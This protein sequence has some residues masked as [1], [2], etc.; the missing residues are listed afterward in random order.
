MRAGR[1][2]VILFAAGIVLLV[3]VPA[4]REAVVECRWIARNRPFGMV[5]P[6]IWLTKAEVTTVAYQDPHDAQIWLGY[7]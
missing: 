4:L 1:L 7:A 2:T 3:A 5:G 6:E